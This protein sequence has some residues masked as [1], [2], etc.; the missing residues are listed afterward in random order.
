VNNKS[1]A[2][3][4]EIT[5]SRRRSLVSVSACHAADNAGNRHACDGRH[6][7]VHGDCSDRRLKFSDSSGNSDLPGEGGI[8][9]VAMIAWTVDD[10]RITVEVQIRSEN[11]GISIDFE[12][13]YPQVERALIGINEEGPIQGG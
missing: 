3:W 13:D 6:G 8:I 1:Q 7:W 4:V 12:I 5:A 9:H 11:D 2:S 10:G